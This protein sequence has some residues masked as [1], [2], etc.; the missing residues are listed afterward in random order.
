MKKAFLFLSFF[1]VTS[2]LFAQKIG[3]TSATVAFDA[4]TA[5]D[6]LPKA[7]NKTV[8]AEI[9]TKTGELG[10]EAAVKNFAFSNPRIQEHFNGD[11]WLNSTK[12][13]L[14]TF[15]GKINN[16][17]EVNFTKDGTYSVKVAGELTIKDVTKPI[18]TTGTITV[19]NGAVNAI[20]SFTFKLADYGI[21]G[22]PIDAGKVAKEPTVTVSADLK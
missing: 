7:A 5:I 21:T 11:N 19:K 17:K 14:F 13:P 12:F 4:S 16:I 15:I 9:D 8:V 3:T 2:V 20:A 22:V 10:F 1:G 6:N 18:S